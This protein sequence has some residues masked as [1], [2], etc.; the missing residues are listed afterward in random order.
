MRRFLL[1]FLLLLSGCRVGPVYEPPCPV[2]PNEW[3]A[4]PQENVTPLHEVCYWWEVFQDERLNEL[5]GL[6]VAS[7]PNLAV[8]LARIEEAWA[9]AGISHADLLPQ[10]NAN[11]SYNS[12]GELFKIYLP[13][14]GFGNF[15]PPGSFPTVYRVHMLQYGFPLNLNYE[16]DLWGKY[17]SQFDSAVMNAEAQTE[18]YH[19]ALLSLTANLATSY[20]NLRTLD[21]TVDILKRTIESRQKD[22]QINFSRKEKGL[23]GSIDVSQASLALSNA[24]SDYYNAFE[25]RALQEN[26]IATYIGVPSSLLQIDRSPLKD[27]PPIIPPGIPSTILLQRPDIAQAERTMASEHFLINSAYADFFPALDLTGAIGFLSP[28]FRQFMTWKSRYWNIG[29]NVAQTIFDGGRKQSALE[30][31]WARFNEAEGAYKQQVLVAFQEVEDALSNL[32][33]QAKQGESLS[34]SVAAGREASRLSKNRFKN[35]LVNYFEVTQNDRLL[36]EAEQSHATILGLRYLSTIQLIKAL[37]GAWDSSKK[38]DCA[39]ELDLAE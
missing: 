6:A 16:I 24:E 25:R 12:T 28:D 13:K 1:I 4:P 11:P 36:L 26:L 5:E 3:K 30:A 15:L 27:E 37:G 21:L 18:A 35:G 32:E 31:T 20:Y 10:I 34:N 8:A 7:N 14:N 39:F 38:I 17:R 29:A 19:T 33:F 9:M 2:T 23:S 22:Y